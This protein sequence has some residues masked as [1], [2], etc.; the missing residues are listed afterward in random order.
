MTTK[1]VALRAE[2]FRSLNNVSIPLHPLTV[3]V[4]PN[5]A[6]KSNVLDL[7]RFLGDSARLDLGPALDI[8]GGFDRVAFRGEIAP[9]WVSIRVRTQTTK[10]ASA[11]AFNEYELRFRQQRNRSGVSVLVRDEEFNFTR[12]RGGALRISVR[13]GAVDIVDQRSAGQESS[14][15]IGL[16]QGALGLSTLPKLPDDEGG[17]DV[18]QMAELF[19]TFRVVDIDVAAARE[20]SRLSGDRLEADGAN[21]AA[22]LHVLS[23][24]ESVWQDFVADAQ[25]IVPGLQNV[26]FE[27]IGGAAR[28]VALVL[29]E[30]GLRDPTPLS[31]ASFGTI[32]ALALLAVLYDPNP[33]LLT[34]IEEIDHG[35]HPYAF[36]IIV[37][38]LRQASARTQ[39]LIAT[40]SPVLVNRLLPEELIVCERQ[41]DGSSRIPAIAPTEVARLMRAADGALQLGE[42]WFSGSLGGVPA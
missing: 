12:Y 42:A 3:L 24:E 2:G 26:E 17:A 23:R 1:L 38:R 22:F 10:H 13:G 8:R 35:L 33:P 29:R 4:G 36:D 14:R 31:D 40:H 16:R 15:S 39:F 19:E 41:A 5:N 21:L 7:I 18:R 11:N 9:R 27:L 28:G 37:E 32:R 34:C 30:E 20:P 25:G 6:G